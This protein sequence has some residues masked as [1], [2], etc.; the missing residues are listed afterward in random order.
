MKSPKLKTWI[1]AINSGNIKNKTVIILNFI[2]NNSGCTLLD[3]R[4]GLPSMPHQTTTAIISN[5]MDE[6]IVI[7]DGEVESHGSHYS[8]YHFVF[9]DEQRIQNAKHRKFEK[10]VDWKKRGIEEFA[11]YLAPSTISDL[12]KAIVVTVSEKG[13][14]ILF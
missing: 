5:L 8:K 11:S 13:Q 10:F 2:R 12:Q 7:M 4:A 3:F 6:G 14:I 9:N 1:E